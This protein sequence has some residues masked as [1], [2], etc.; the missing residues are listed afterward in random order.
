[1]LLRGRASKTAA[2]FAI[3]SNVSGC[4]CA[5]VGGAQRLARAQLCDGRGGGHLQSFDL[6]RLHDRRR[7]V[8]MAARVLMM[9]VRVLKIEIRA[10]NSANKGFNVN[11]Y[12]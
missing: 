2:G 1:M 7:A 3:V 8:I 5:R 10:L 11:A 6:V 9:A 12:G 4:V